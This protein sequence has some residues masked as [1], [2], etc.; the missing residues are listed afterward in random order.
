MNAIYDAPMDKDGES[1]YNHISRK[2]DVILTPA[3]QGKIRYGCDGVLAGVS[4]EDPFGGLNR[5]ILI[6]YLKS[7]HSGAAGSLNE[8]ENKGGAGMG[9]HQMIEASSLT[10]FNIHRDLKTEVICLFNVDL[11]EA[12][13]LANSSFHFFYHK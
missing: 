8:A 12:K 1:K 11:K 6:N 10:I 2:E 4:V 3:E 9:L 5:D 7:C 13:K